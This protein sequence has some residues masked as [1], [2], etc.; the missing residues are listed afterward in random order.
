MT[1]TMT[2]DYMTVMVLLGLSLRVP[3]SLR[4]LHH[5]RWY[6][7][8][9]GHAWSVASQLMQGHEFYGPLPGHEASIKD[10]VWSSP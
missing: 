10:R 7:L 5:P 6:L 8:L 3:Q 2:V 4:D 9:E 1:M